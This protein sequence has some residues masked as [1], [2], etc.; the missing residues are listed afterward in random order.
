[1]QLAKALKKSKSMAVL[2][3]VGCDIKVCLLV[4]A[5]G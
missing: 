5:C 3:L 1:M 2:L 4:A